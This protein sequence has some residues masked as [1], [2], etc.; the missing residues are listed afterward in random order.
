MDSM[1]AHH[2]EDVNKKVSEENTIRVIIPSDLTEILQP[3]NISV[4]KTN[5]RQIWDS[6]M[7]IGEHSFTK[8]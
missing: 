2:T 8:T 7:T 4:N 6:W 1:Q 3:L 5:L